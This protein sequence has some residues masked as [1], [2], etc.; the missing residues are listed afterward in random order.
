MITCVFTD[1]GLL[2]SKI[3]RH[4][5]KLGTDLVCPLL[6]FVVSVDD[7]DDLASVERFSVNFVECLGTHRGCRGDM[8]KS[9]DRLHVLL[10]FHKVN[11]LV[12]SGRRFDLAESV[13]LRD[14]PIGLTRLRK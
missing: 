5:V 11:D 3:A 9:L 1:P 10:A 6:A 14:L 4:S 7:G 12:F 13:K 2:K 8:T